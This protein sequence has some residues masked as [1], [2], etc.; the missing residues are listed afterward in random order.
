MLF[1]VLKSSIYGSRS[2]S[3]FDQAC[4]ACIDQIRSVDS[5]QTI[6]YPLVVGIFTTNAT[7][8]YND[9]VSNGIPTKGN[10]MYDIV[11]PYYFEDYPR[12]DP[13][14][15]PSDDADWYW[16]SYILPQISYFGASQCYCGETFPGILMVVDITVT[17]LY[18]TICRKPLRF[19]WLTISVLL[20]WAFKCGVFLA[21]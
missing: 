2:L 3:H 9:L 5:S 4:A 14:N 11:H 19:G 1:T 13:C 15:N 7:A 12:M 18:I 17:P 21:K 20:A 6:M 10:I 8:F 16:N